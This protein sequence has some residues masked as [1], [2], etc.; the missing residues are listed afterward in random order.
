MD[1][2]WDIHRIGRNIA[3]FGWASRFQEPFECI[4]RPGRFCLWNAW[5]GDWPERSPAMQ[6]QHPG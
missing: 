3:L 2:Q 6:L 1:R 4:D 5:Y